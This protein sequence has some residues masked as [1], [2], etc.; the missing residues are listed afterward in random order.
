MNEKYETNIPGD[1]LQ[2][3]SHWNSQWLSPDFQNAQ[4][5]TVM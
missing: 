3:E 5:L 1:L 2:A 4:S